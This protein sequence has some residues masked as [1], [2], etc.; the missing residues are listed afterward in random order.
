MAI[1]DRRGVSV[2]AVD[3]PVAGDPNPGLAIKAPV[4]VATTGNITLSGLQTIDGVAVAAGNRVLVWQQTDPTTNG[5]Y[6]ASTG[7]WTRTVDT[8]GND[9][10]ASGVQVLVTQGATYSNLPFVLTSTDPVT[11]GTSA[12]TFV[13]GAVQS[14]RQ[15][16]TTAPLAGGGNLG[17]NRTLSLTINGSLQVT[18]GALAVAPLAGVAHQWVSSINAAGVPQ[19][20]QP[21]VSDIANGA[22]LSGV[23]DTNLTITVSAGGEAALL[24]ATSITLGWTGTL[25]AGRLNSN[26]VQAVTNDTNI[27]GS[28]AAQNL[29]LGFTGT[30]AAGRLNANVV[31][32]ITNDTNITGSI[33]AQVLTLGWTGTLAA[34]RLNANVV[35]AVTNDT[36][37]TG[38]IAAQNLTLGWTGALAVSRGGTGGGTASGT[39]LDNITGFSSTGFLT[40]TG[41]GTYAFQS[42]TNGITNGNLA[43]MAASTIK[44]N[45]TG[46]T[47]NAADLTAA[48]V[49]AMLGTALTSSNDTNVTITLGGSPSVSVLA[50]TSVTMG[51]SGQLAIGRGGTGQ[52]TAQAARGSSGLN[53]E[54]ATPTGDANYT[55]QASDRIVYHTALSAARTD[56]LPA[57]NAVN[58]GQP[59]ILADFRGVVTA[60][61]TVTLAAAGTDKINGVGS[62]IALNAQYGAGIY[63]SDG[64]SRWT[65]FPTSSSGG[66]SG[67]VTNIATTYPLSGGPITSTGTLTSQEP[68]TCGRLTFVSATSLKFAPVYGD[69]IKINGALY[70]IPSAGIAGLANTGVFV[71]GT[72]SQNLAASTVYYVYAFSNSGTITAD[73]AA[74]SHATSSTA[75]NVGVEIKSGDDTRSLIGMIATNA[76]SQFADSASQRFTRSWFNDSG[77]LLQNNFTALRST[78]SSSLVEINSEIRC[79]FLCWA[80][81]VVE[82]FG[83]GVVNNSTNSGPCY[84]GVSFNGSTPITFSGGN[85]SAGSAQPQSGACSAFSNSL[86]EGSVQYATIFGSVLNGGGTLNFPVSVGGGTNNLQYVLAGRVRR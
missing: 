49:Q 3:T 21:T 24:A 78:S 66:G 35:Q 4:L 50:A 80:G 84:F 30:L 63:W 17:V 18:G 58:A 2:S 65:F 5:L 19:L 74:T 47:A 1:T 85:T 28:V 57:A 46:A 77:L 70:Q 54:G 6:N 11:L 53:V 38:A 32:G 22:T 20:A 82:M 62:I 56:T 51:W 67:T 64:V 60:T 59:F 14:T 48:Q 23:N 83:N 16:N 69:L 15:V 44:G 41:P 75:G 8:D 72:A 40:R 36:N 52:S 12:I 26:V 71:N 34:G 27:T 9:D 76:S 43:Q 73:F 55:I 79:Q 13:S 7:P 37:V 61:N 45:N 29:T 10:W 42:T 31:Q 86:S 81:E 33:S 25:A 39:L 68:Q